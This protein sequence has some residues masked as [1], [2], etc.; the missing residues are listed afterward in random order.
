M[1]YA[2]EAEVESVSALYKSFQNPSAAARPFVR[3][4]WNGGRVVKEELIRELD[5][6]KEKGIGGV[7]IN[8]IA[9]PAD[10]N[11]MDYKPLNWLSPEWL[12]MVEAT[13]KAAK[14]RGITCDIIVG[15]GWP[16]G[17][18]FL[19]KDQQI[20]LLALGSRKVTGPQKLEVAK[21]ELL[22]DMNFLVTY[23]QGTKEL[24]SA[25]L[26]PVFMDSF[27]PGINLDSQ[28]IQDKITVE[29]P[30]GDHVL[31]YLVKLT[32]YTSVTHG[33]PGASG[34]LLN[35]YDGKAV[36]AYLN[37][38]SD[39]LN[40]KLGNMGDYF[41]AVFIDSL[42]LR[43]SNW[44]DDMAEEFRKRRGYAL[45]PYL[46]YIL[47]KLNEKSTYN[48]GQL[49]GQNGTNFSTA[50][51]DEI[52]RVRYDFETTRLELFNERFLGT[53][54]S[55]CKKNKVKSRV[56]AY[57]R[58]YYPLESA[59]QLDIPECETWI[60]PDIGGDL[61]EFTFKAG[62]AYRPVNKFVS[63]AARLTGKHIVSCEEITNTSQVFNATLERIK[64]TGDQ[65]NLSGVTHSILHGFNYSPKEIPFPG[66]V[67]YGTFFNERNTWWPYVRSWID[68]KSRLSSVFQNSDL[69]SDVAIMFPHADMWSE[70]GLQYQQYPQIVYPEYAN[71]I[72]EGIHQNGGGCDYINEDI[73]QKSTFSGGMIH[74]NS[75]SYKTL[76]L[77]EV[78]SV[79]PGTVEALRKFAAVGGKIIFIE[80]EPV[81]S[82][83]VRNHAERDQ[84]VKT[85]IYSL[86]QVYPAKVTLY[87]KPEKEML[88][89]YKEVQSK[90]NIVPFVK[91]DKPVEHVSQNY[92]KTKDADIFFFSNYHGEKSHQF[93]AEF[94]TVKNRTAWLWDSE[95]GKKYL[96]PYN[97]QKNK[98]DI[99]L[100]PA[101][102]MLIVFTDEAKGEV[103][104]I[105]KLNNEQAITVNGAWDVR[106]EK[107]YEQPRQVRMEKL[108]DFKNDK[109]LQSFAG[110]ILYRNSFDT[111]NAQAYHY[112][113]LGKVHGI[114]DVK[115][116]G[117]PLGFKWYGQHLY[118][119]SKALKTGRNTLE[120]KVTTV[121]GN[122]AKSLKDNPV[123]QQWTKS[124]PLSSIGM[125]G[126]VRIV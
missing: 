19:T 124:Q 11:A 10:N 60:R 89:W 75:R 27:K 74:Y 13:V 88:S 108:I 16:F 100:N 77:A 54:I 31:Y 84:Q 44:C 91:I 23:K 93:T 34:P 116:N 126:P 106:L 66:W 111:G 71:N 96:Y 49:I 82:Y 6:L 65:S 1:L 107:V 115:L 8:P 25:S 72:W 14:Q 53:F 39:A 7:E 17:G 104:R 95:S 105:P 41:R 97:T 4:W 94:N 64:I 98:L 70:V 114:S 30:E 58:E 103:Y 24:F 125:I 85:G 112:L 81:K 43:G 92:Y 37:R 47:F 52:N 99:L 2:S 29:V 63:S 50:A 119:L 55:W 36:Q 110:T 56:Q 102:S 22:T 33:S 48:G 18:E 5:M 40:S 62:R 76:L 42:E 86:K 79:A 109:E 45:E 101:T 3:W 38:M 15:S 20:Q 69:Q 80:K 9:F 21:D 67:R 113:D 120:I 32:G 83:G 87:P 122:Y 51:Q 118:D 46:P 26:A 57:G 68:Y 35:H 12:E 121:L 61:A 78:E 117:Q 90:L 73:L 59:M 123:A 28:I